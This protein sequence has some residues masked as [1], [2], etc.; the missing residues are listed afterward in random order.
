MKQKVQ[1]K[2]QKVSNSYFLSKTRKLDNTHEKM[3]SDP[4][5]KAV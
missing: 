1:R 3:F 4:G 5:Y 2:I